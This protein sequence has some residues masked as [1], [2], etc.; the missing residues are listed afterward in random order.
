MPDTAQRRAATALFD[1]TGCFFQRSRELLATAT[2][3]GNVRP[4]KRGCSTGQPGRHEPEL[5]GHASSQLVHPGAV[6]PA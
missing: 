4:F 3:A 2:A 1:E 5:P 6:V